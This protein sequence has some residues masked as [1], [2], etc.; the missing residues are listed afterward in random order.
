MSVRAN[1][2][3]DLTR[4]DLVTDDEIAAFR[5][6]YGATHGKALDAYELWLTF[7][8]SVVKRHRLQAYWTTDPDEPA[9]PAK[10]ILGYL[11]LYTILGYGEGIRYEASHAHDLG[12]PAVA[13]LQVLELAFIRSGPRGMD[14]AW[15]SARTQI[16]DSAANSGDVSSLFPPGWTADPDRFDCGCVPLEPDLSAAEETGIRRWYTDLCG[17]VP[18]GVTLLMATRPGLLKAY[19]LRL[20]AAMRGPLPVQLWAFMEVQA[21]A[22]TSNAPALR[23][24]IAVAR[25]LGLTRAD[26]VEAVGWGMQ[27]SGPEVFDVAADVIDRVFSAPDRALA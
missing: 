10:S 8:P 5:A 16:A 17:E 24:A 3:L 25:G 27:Y 13:V 2:G 14:A 12:L 19:H 7:N 23:R 1:R 6:A 9:Y 20:H 26:V 22:G 15:Q 11:Y 21:A 4:P 18:S